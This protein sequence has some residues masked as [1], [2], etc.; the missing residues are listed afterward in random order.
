MTK[1]I[2]Q[3][4]LLFIFSISMAQ[5][6][7]INFEAGGFGA[8]WTWSVF[9]N[10]AN[11]A[12]EI[13][14]N[15]D[16]TGINT[17]G[18]VMKF[19]A[20]QGG[21]PWAGCES[22]HGA[23]L[24]PFAWDENNRIV[25]VMVWKSVISDVGIKFASNTGWAQIELK[26]PNTVINQWEELTFDF[27]NYV[28][29]PDGNGTLDQIIIFP[30]F[31]TNGRTQDNIVY[32]DNITFS[33]QNNQETVN[34]PLDFELATGTY[35]FTNF[36]GALTTVIENPDASGIN[37]SSQVAQTTKNS[38]A[39]TWAGSFIELAS[40]IDFSTAQSIKIKTW[41]PQSGITVKIKLEN[42]ANPDINTEVDVTNTVANA[43]EELTFNFPSTV[44]STSYQRVVV[45]FNFG[46]NGT[47]ENYY[48]DDIMLASSDN[49]TPEIVL[50]LDFEDEDIVYTFENFG[51]AL[52]TVIENPDA[53]GENTSAHVA[54]MTKTSGSETWAGSFIELSAP[55]DFSTGQAISMKSWAPAAGLTVLMKLENF[56][57]PNINI[58][59][60]TTTS[61]ANAWETIT[62]DFPGII[63]ANNY[64]RIV[65]FY[66]FGTAGTGENYYFDDITLE[67]TEVEVLELPLDFESET[68]AYNFSN[69][70]GAETTIIENPDA[71][72]INTSAHVAQTLKSSGSEPWA[73]SFIELGTPINF[74]TSDILKIKTW[75]PQS[76]I[77]IKM[78]LENLANPDINVELD[79]T[80]TVANAWEELSFDFS[81]INNANNYQRIVVFFNFGTAGNGAFYYFDDIELYDPL[82]TTNFDTTQVIL[83]PNPT[84][85]SITIKSPAIINSYAIININGQIVMQ[86]SDNQMESTIN[87]SQLQSGVYF[88]KI[89][90]ENTTQNLRFIKN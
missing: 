87:V 59:V 50:P 78:K 67:E 19:T 65:V 32:V 84:S 20:L 53:S 26:V 22:Q 3:M 17:S 49:N 5:N 63:N 73:G 12:V 40:P 61:V 35:E 79:V 64:Q 6:S 4:M 42:L 18:N 57:N 51:G 30:D 72:G 9:E 75:A 36:G 47:G 11:P 71:T 90:S 14:A 27:S 29:P 86:G 48:F 38:G 1:K 10:G 80:N 60:T 56:S 33:D 82:S 62:F 13:I 85:E 77:V 34:L 44:S 83:Y 37:T 16:P 89:V 8:N 41:A 31:N 2:T 70:G 39:E 54:Q 55:I 28:N 15:P 23:D 76:G 68:L 66:N 74:S 43:W 81:G 58:E 45:F 88:V 21:Q 25:K 24:G 46:T 7:P 69:F 52:T